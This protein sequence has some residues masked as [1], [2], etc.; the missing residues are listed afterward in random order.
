[1]QLHMTEQERQSSVQKNQHLQNHLQQQEA[2]IK[3]M[4]KVHQ[5]EV[6]QVLGVL[7]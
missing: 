1:M 4:R 6:L 7:T 3:R 5:E 2:E